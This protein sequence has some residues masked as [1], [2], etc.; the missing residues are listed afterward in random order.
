MKREKKTWLMR[1]A[2]NHILAFL[3]DNQPA[4]WEEIIQS[5][6][7]HCYRQT[8]ETQLKALELKG[9]VKYCPRSKTFSLKG[10]K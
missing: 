1:N 8:I 10:G 7:Y 6:N 4:N 9:K 5:F 3:R 2:E